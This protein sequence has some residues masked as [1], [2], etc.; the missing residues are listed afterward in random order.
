MPLIMTGVM[1]I[2]A[3]FYPIIKYVVVDIDPLVL[4]FYMIFS[5]IHPTYSLLYL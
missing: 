3:P 5:G 2:W 1:I 4:S